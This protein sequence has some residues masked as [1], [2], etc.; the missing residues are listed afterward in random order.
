MGMK[1]LWRS[2]GGITLTSGYDLINELGGKI[3]MLDAMPALIEKRGREKALTECNYRKALRKLILEERSK[4]TPVT[5]I[6]DIVRGD[7]KTADLK[8]ARDVAESLYDAA[9]EAC[10]VYKI[11]SKILENQIQRELSSLK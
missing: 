8:F 4:G 1:N 11:E 3:K 2:L 9:K 6:S 5:V 10:N 7:E